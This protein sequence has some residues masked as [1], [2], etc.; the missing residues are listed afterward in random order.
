LLAVEV[1]M[2][3]VGLI[4]MFIMYFFDIH[5][6]MSW[7]LTGTYLALV[8][9]LGVLITNHYQPMLRDRYMWYLESTRKVDKYVVRVL[10]E[11]GLEADH[12]KKEEGAKGGFDSVYHVRNE[13]FKIGLV[14]SI[15]GVY[16]YVGPIEDFNKKVTRQVMDLLDREYFKPS[17]S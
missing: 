12:R 10:D 14:D 13:G 6:W 8:L 16:V 5:S 15:E 17:E 7:T 2:V 1:A 9:L 3:L 4:V 11:V